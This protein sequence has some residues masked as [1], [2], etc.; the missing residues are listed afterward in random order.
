MTDLFADAADTQLS[1]LAPLADRMRPRTLDEVVGQDHLT[2]PNGRLRRQLAGGHVPNM[3]LVGPPGSGKTTLARLIAGE[4]GMALHEL[5]AVACGLA[6]VRKVIADA[7]QRLGANQ[8]QTILFLDEI[9]RFNRAQQDALLPAV[10]AG[11]I[12]LVGAT[13][14]NPYVSINRA[15]LS[16]LVTFELRV[17]DAT[18]IERLVREAVGD[19]DR[20]LARSRAWTIDDDAIEAI[21]SRAGGDARTALT[22]LEGASFVAPDD[23]GTGVVTEESVHEASDRRRIAYDRAGDAHYDTISA[24]IKSMRASQPDQ[25]LLYLAAMIEGGEDPM[26]IARRLAIFASED[27]GDADPQSLLLATAAL[28]VTE[29]I[30]LPEAAITLAHVTR[31]CAEAPKSRVAVNDIGAATRQVQEQGS[32]EVPLHLT[33]RKGGAGHAS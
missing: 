3:V 13:T 9:H 15:L 22:L 8:R 11:T 23:G 17:L 21:V 4:T 27:V 1:A 26:F 29:K 12:R 28:T 6:D 16:R 18:D 33:N 32:P 5:S 19:S 25:A 14:E 30:G 20:G 10:E 7:T 24:Y 2:G 31:H